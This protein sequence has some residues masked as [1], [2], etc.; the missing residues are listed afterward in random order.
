M[1]KLS[2]PSSGVERDALNKELAAAGHDY[3]VAVLSREVDA[4]GRAVLDGNGR[5][6]RA[7]QYV[8]VKTPAGIANSVQTA[9]TQI[10]SEHDPSG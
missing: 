2:L 3:S 7:A 6:V 10:V 5:P 1:L 9:I 8:L 4:D